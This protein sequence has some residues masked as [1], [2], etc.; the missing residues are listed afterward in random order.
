MVRELYQNRWLFGLRGVLAIIFGVLAFFWSGLTA[1]ALVYMFGIYAI[2]DGILTI[3]AAV[4]NRAARDRWWLGLLEG[5]VD[6]A[7]G[8]IAILFPT[9]AAFVLLIVIAIWAIVTG[10]L[11]IATAIR[12][13]REIENEW[14]MGLSG[15]VSVALGVIILFNP[16][17]GLL[18]IVWVIG[19]Y[20][21]IFGVLMLILAFRAGRL[22]PVTGEQTGGTRVYPEA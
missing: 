21:I 4:R 9:L 1:V 11:E 6:I 3:S 20:A 7:A 10:I 15:L 8:V 5:I 19:A 16:A 18:G 17:A 13:R 22:P 14:A 12:L 2:L